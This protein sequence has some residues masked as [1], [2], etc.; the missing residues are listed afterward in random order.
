M[1]PTAEATDAP[2]RKAGKPRKKADA[3]RRAASRSARRRH[4]GSSRRC[5][6]LDPPDPR[7]ARPAH[8][9][10]ARHGVG[11]RRGV[12]R[13]RL[14]VEGH[15]AGASAPWRGVARRALRDAGR[16]GRLSRLAAQAREGREPSR[17]SEDGCLAQPGAGAR[18]PADPGG[19]PAA[20]GLHRRGV[21]RARRDRARSASLGRTRPADAH[22]VGRRGARARS[23]QCHLDP[24]PRRA[25]RA[26]RGQPHGDPQGQPDAGQPSCPCSSADSRRSSSSASSGSSAAAARSART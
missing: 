6:H 25:V 21:V 11:G 7:P 2:A 3:A 4:R 14:D 10:P 26:A 17:W 5:E 16:A 18:V 23:G 12:G 24:G 22:P 15:R 19:Q 8:G 13:C 20:V 1:P 9:E